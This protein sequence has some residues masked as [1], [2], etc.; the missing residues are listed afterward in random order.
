MKLATALLLAFTLA[1]VAVHLTSGRLLRRA[2]EGE[3][4]RR[5]SVLNIFRFEGIY[6]LALMAYVGW[7]RSRFLLIP[8]VVMAALHVVAWAVA[9]RRREW[10]VDAGGAAARARIL[11]GVQAFDLAE[12]VVLIYVAWVL[13]RALLRHG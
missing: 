6:Y 3:A 13:G 2:W 9:E 10:L 5:L 7:Q 4:P 11:A 1:M 12:T 8:L